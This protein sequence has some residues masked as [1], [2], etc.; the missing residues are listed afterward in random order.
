MTKRNES[1]MTFV[2]VSLAILGMSALLISPLLVGAMV[3][4][5]G[6]SGKQAGYIM[7]AEMSGGVVSAIILAVMT[8]T[9]DRKKLVFTGLLVFVISNLISIFLKSFEGLIALRFAS[10]L[11]EG[12]LLIAAYSSIPLLKRQERAWAFI[13][14]GWY[15]FSIIAFYVL[16]RLYLKFGGVSG[17][18]LL[19][20][21]GAVALPFIGKLPENTDAETPE[22]GLNRKESVPHIS[23]LKQYPIILGIFAMLVFYVAMGMDWTYL[24]R[25]GLQAGGTAT[26]VGNALVISSVAGAIGGLTAAALELRVGRYLPLILSAVL[27]S[28]GSALLLKNN[29]LL[30]FT[31]GICALQFVWSFAQ[32]YLLG[33]LSKADPSGR[34]LS[35]MTVMQLSG[36]ALGPFLAASMLFENNYSPIILVCAG[37][38]VLSFVLA[39]PM[40]ISTKSKVD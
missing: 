10:G 28:L 34:A 16:P 32:P 9:I 19:A 20:L 38:T 15:A 36:L 8:K 26:S 11:A 31:A 14:F 17:F 40:L 27:F 12:A 29:G 21:V 22:S 1:Q 6:L 2:I 39:I 4:Y 3:D 5:Y 37:L 25:I 7:S 23:L 24:D 13:T 30:V 35:Y 33:P 18:A